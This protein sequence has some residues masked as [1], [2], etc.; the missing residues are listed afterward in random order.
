VVPPYYD[1]LI[2]KLIV[3]DTDR[4]AALAR[5]RRALTELELEG[6]TTTRE[7]ALEI[8]SSDEFADGDYSTGYLAEAGDRLLSLAA[9]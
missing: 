9:R 7:L 5:A 1:S 2:A 3:W 8:L 6:I 4:P